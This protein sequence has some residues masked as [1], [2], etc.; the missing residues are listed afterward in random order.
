MVNI[1]YETYQEVKKI[2]KKGRK[3]KSPTEFQKL[4]Y[5]IYIGDP[6]S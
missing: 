1:I 6:S 3:F 5:S 2:N 4:V